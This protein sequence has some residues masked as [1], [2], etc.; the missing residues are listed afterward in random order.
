MVRPEI[1]ES[2]GPVSFLHWTDEAETL[3]RQRLDQALFLAAIADCGSSRIHAGR[4]RGIGDD[5]SIPNRL[6]QIFLR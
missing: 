1:G 3:A 5:A 4:Q 6:Y 2:A